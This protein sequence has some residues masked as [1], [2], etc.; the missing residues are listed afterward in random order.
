MAYVRLLLSAALLVALSACQSTAPPR[1]I[2][3]AEADPVM[4]RLFSLKTLSAFEVTVP[5]TAA[6]ARLTRFIDGH[7]QKLVLGEY[8]DGAE[9]GYVA[10][11][12]TRILALDAPFNNTQLLLAPFVISNQGSGSFWYLG[13]F[14]LDGAGG[15]IRQLDAS[16][17]GDRIAVKNLN[18]NGNS[19]LP[20]GINAELL[21]H[22]PQQVMAES[23]GLLEIRRFSV[24]AQGTIVAD[25]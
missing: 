6:K 2:T 20:V 14:A 8:A 23:P 3:Q 10:L 1:E 11:D 4:L 17:L 12:Y 9:R 15:T 16:F 18:V 13:L 24:T 25:Q 5:D 19:L 7:G 22:G 21:V